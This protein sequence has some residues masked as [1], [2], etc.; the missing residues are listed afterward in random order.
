M[1]KNL[2][3]NS[4]YIL[5]QQKNIALKSTVHFKFENKK[6]RHNLSALMYMR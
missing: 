2:G 6:S 3:Y 5:I 1:K 4:Y